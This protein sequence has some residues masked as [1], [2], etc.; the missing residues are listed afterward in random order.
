MEINDPD[1]QDF[2]DPIGTSIPQETRERLHSVWDE[3]SQGYNQ[4]PAELLS[5]TLAETY[6]DLI[7]LKGIQFHSLCEH[8]LLPFSGNVHI[9]Y[10]PGKIVGISKLVR[11]VECFSRRFQI[12]ERLTS[13]IADAI[14]EHLQARGVGVVV[15][16]NHTC[17]SCRGVRNEAQLVT[18][19]MLGEFR[20]DATLRSEFLQLLRL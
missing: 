14:Q 13:Q 2:E 4:S 8:H 16:A 6:D 10:L 11:L 5:H 15:Q 1:P 18:S 9:G 17:M 20:N 12:Q 19:V 7:I 3:F